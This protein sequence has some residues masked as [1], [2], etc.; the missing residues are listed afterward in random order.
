MGKGTMGRGTKKSMNHSM[1]E[2]D[3]LDKEFFEKKIEKLENEDMSIEEILKARADS[4][5]ITDTSSVISNKYEDM[6]RTTVEEILRSLADDG[7][8]RKKEKLEYKDMTIEEILRAR[9]DGSH[10]TDTSKVIPKKFHRANKNSPMEMSSKVR[11]ST[12]REVIQVPKKL[13]RDPRF[14]SLSRGTFDPDGFKKRYSFVFDEEYPKEKE[15]LK[16]LIKKS[17]DPNVVEESQKQISSMD[18]QI[19]SWSRKS[20]ESEI[21]SEH[22]KKEREAAKKGKQPYYLKKSEIRERKLIKKY[23]ELKAVGKLD[24]YIEK[25]QKRNASKDHRYM[26][27][28][29]S[30]KNTQE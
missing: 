12:F 29:R 15:R 21:L 23:N 18:K 6:S 20:V 5:H 11:V 1:R 28:R 16:M 30:D 17:K 7:H 22:I 26:P 9:A 25:R 2:H 24:S 3:E 4:S 10:N 27:Y 8:K 19:K 14:D 13:V